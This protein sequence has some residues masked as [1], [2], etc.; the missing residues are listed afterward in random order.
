LYEKQ[1]FA[2]VDLPVADYVAINTLGEALD[3]ARSFEFPCLLK[4]RRM[5]YDGRGQ[6]LLT[7]QSDLHDAWPSLGD[8]PCLLERVVKFE[9][10][11]SLIAVRDISKKICF[12][13]WTTNEH[14][15][16]ILRRS[17]VA[18]E[19]GA[20]P[21][22]ADAERRVTS[23]LEELDYVGVLAVEFFEAGD[24]LIANEIAPRVHNSGHWTMNG[25]VTS[26]FENHIRAIAGLP[27]G[28][29]AT[30]GYPAMVNLIGSIPQL[31]SMLAIPDIHVHV[32][33]K[34]PRPGRK[35]GHV[36]IATSSEEH[37]AVALRR[38][39]PLVTRDGAT[40]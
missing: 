4:S 26:Q 7:H 5:G 17:I 10:E 3:A 12:W 30:R 6:R 39:Q 24:S 31:D 2:R 35:V 15:D 11:A 37:R 1:L 19:H 25:A 32:Y 13:S 21:A 18:V 36:N 40:E 14:R 23:L 34:Q 9:R 20:S 8:V 29:T 22:R 28:S 38:L 16:G 27:L 33:G